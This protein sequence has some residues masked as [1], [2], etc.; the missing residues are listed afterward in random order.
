MDSTR[1][2]LAWSS[3]QP[4]RSPTFL[5]GSTMYTLTVR[6]ELVR[7]S[8]V[9]NDLCTKK[10]E[11]LQSTLDRRTIVKSEPAKKSTIQKKI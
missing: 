6:S 11:G 2:S 3:G 1:I 7:K 9:V 8:T 5:E 10:I 4:V